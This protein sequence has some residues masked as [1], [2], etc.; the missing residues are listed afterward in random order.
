MKL[1][2]LWPWRR[3]KSLRMSIDDYAKLI[4][5]FTFNG[6]YYQPPYS[7][8]LQGDRE[9]I[10]AN[11][12]SVVNGA[13]KANGIVFACMLARR[14]IFTEA[15]FQFRSRRRQNGRPGPLFGTSALGPLEKPF[16]GGVTADLLA[17]MIDDADLAGNWFG[18]RDQNEIVRLRPDWVDIALEP[19]TIVRGDKRYSPVG[20]RKRGYMYF[21]GGDR[22]KA[23]VPLTLSEVA[24][25]APNPDPVASWRGVSWLTPVIRE[26][27]SDKQMTIH[28]SKF[29]ENGATP[30]MVVKLPEM[31]EQQFKDFK[32][33]TDA[34]HKG[35]A[36]AYKTMYLGGGADLTV[37]GAD[38]KQLDFK[39][40]QGASETR[41]A[42]AS[43]IHPVIVGLSEGL[44][45]SSLNQGNFNAARRLTADKVIRPLW[46]NAAA[47]LEQIVPPPPDAE[48]WYDERDVAFLRED[49]RDI[50]EI[51]AK[52]AEALRQ[53]T[54]AGYEPDAAVQYLLTDDLAQL[55]GHHGGLFSVQLQEPGSAQTTEP[56]VSAAQDD[57]RVDAKLIT[58]MVQKVY[59]GV[60]KVIT[61]DE[62]RQM[63]NAAGANL[64]IPGPLAD[65]PTAPAQPSNQ[66]EDVA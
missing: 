13:Y 46:R 11:F 31:T 37:V 63:L 40:V 47:S 36:N 29:L 38:F 65:P 9:T 30:N 5:S 50:A 22:A 24:H 33:Q 43:G 56:T 16:P 4:S 39:Q 26:I 1:S 44:A 42:A 54:D 61:A 49:Q 45:G 20:F 19:R 2:A 7:Q 14:A 10:E 58:E 53:L 51:Q 55:S 18:F 23:G 15:R 52:Q 28:K 57:A 64:D 32:E 27:Q 3:G 35:A 21:E 41:I 59:L 66:E 12:E 6:V 48:I 62:A 8:T 34:I 60:G 17:R 25:F